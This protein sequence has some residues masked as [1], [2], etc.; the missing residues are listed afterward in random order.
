MTNITADTV[1]AKTVKSDKVETEKLDSNS[2][3]IGGTT[4][5]GGTLVAD[6][7]ILGGW[8][9]FAKGEKLFGTSPGGQECQFEMIDYKV[10][11]GEQPTTPP[12]YVPPALT[13]TQQGYQESGSA[14]SGSS[15]A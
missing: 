2:A 14:S 10:V 15:T 12:D 11:L 5:S 1:T 4:I 9:L 13:D 3:E 8:T 6:K 7:I